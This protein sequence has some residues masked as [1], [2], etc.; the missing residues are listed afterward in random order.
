M[1]RKLRPEHRNGTSVLPEAVDLQGTSCDRAKF[2]AP[3]SLV[4]EQWP[5][6]AFTTP[7]LLPKGVQPPSAPPNSHPW[8]F[9]EVDWPEPEN[10]AHSE[11]RVR[12]SGRVSEDNDDAARKRPH[13][14]REELKLALARTMRVLPQP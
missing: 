1:Y 8:E 4:S 11:I 3:A 7:E 6:V 14:V 5:A 9:F 10:E 2:R 12:R 13:T